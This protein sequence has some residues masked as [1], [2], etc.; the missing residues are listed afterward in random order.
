M[1][2]V[3][4]AE[5]VSSLIIT[6]CLAVF[7]IWA[8]KKFREAD[9]LEKPHGIILLVEI[10]IK[11]LYD[12]FKSIMPKKFEKNYY[13]YFAMLFIWLLVANLSGLLGFEAPTSS[14]SVTSALT[15]VTFTLIQINSI[16]HNGIGAY[17]KSNL[18]PPT[19][20]FGTIS[21]LI[22]ISMRIFCNVLSGS[23][24]MAL[25]YQFTSFLSYKVI[26]FNFLG[27]VLAPLLHAYFDI[28][29]GVIQALVFVTLSTILISIENPDEE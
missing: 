2:I 8:G 19:N 3:I 18:I 28:F 7:F 15:L 27:P 23:F 16:K 14:W 17:L 20:L 12:Y 21:P 13:P 25:I 22:S 26:P 6:I 10:L 1:K 5:L 11:W 29:S 24:I 4:Q 9:P